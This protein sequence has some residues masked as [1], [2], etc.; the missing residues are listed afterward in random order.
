M[1]PVVLLLDLYIA[2]I[3]GILYIW[4]KAFPIV[5]EEIHGFYNLLLLEVPLAVEPL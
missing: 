5:F 4:F 2:L 1:E 3:Y